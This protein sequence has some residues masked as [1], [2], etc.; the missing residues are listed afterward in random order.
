M[1]RKHPKIVVIGASI[2]GASI[3]HA[4]AKAGAPVTLIDQG[5]AGA[6][7]TARSFGWVNVN[8]GMA[9]AYHQL[10]QEAVQ[11]WRRLDTELAGGIVDK[12]RG[13][14]VWH[15]QAD[16]TEA[17]VR[18][19][20]RWGYDT[21]IVKRAEIM[22]LEPAL[23][24]P[25]DIAAFSPDE[26]AVEPSVV[27]KTLV[28]AAGEA[29]AKVLERTHVDAITTKSGHVT[30]VRTQVSEI[31]ADAVILA[32][33]VGAKALAGSLGIALPVKTSPAL[34][35]QLDTPV[36]LVNRILSCPTFE[37][38]QTPDGRLLAAEDCPA[39]ANKDDAYAKARETLAAMKAGLRGA[40]GVQLQSVKI[41]QR[42]IPAD[43]LPIVGF[44]AEIGGL[45]TAV[46]HAGATLAPAI[47]ECA[48]AEILE[49][50]ELPALAPCR[51]GRFAT[52]A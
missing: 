14:L 43:G 22:A 20:K 1:S 16:R 34:L 8:H 12:W 26:G 42:P 45:F 24:A 23:I 50:K 35:L 37:L 47:G 17:F 46:M 13:A 36:P 44:L 27:T 3:A 21:R 31:Q 2:V 30:G 19:H 41:G 48:V 39:D 29:G 49:D 6:G 38:R 51:P 32:A 18:D 28:K 5:M 40:D 52:K 11:A 25:P 33:G 9:E 4:L 10:R 7:V 15:D